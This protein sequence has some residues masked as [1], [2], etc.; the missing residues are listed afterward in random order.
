MVWWFIFVSDC[1]MVCHKKC[2]CKI[3]IDCSAFC[4]KKV[5]IQS[6]KHSGEAGIS[7]SCSI[8]RFLRA[9]GLV[10]WW[11][12]VTTLWCARLQPGQQQDPCANCAGDNAGTRGNERTVHRGHLQ[13]VGLSQSHEGATP[14][15]GSRWAIIDISRTQYQIGKTTSL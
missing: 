9:L 4:S 3:V 14:A 12:W 2:I 15:V 11:A 6:S 13:E 7:K 10:W 8:G 1:K 5:R